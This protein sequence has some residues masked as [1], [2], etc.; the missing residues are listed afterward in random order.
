MNPLETFKEFLRDEPFWREHEKAVAIIDEMDRRGKQ[1]PVIFI[2][3]KRKGYRAVRC[4]V[5]ILK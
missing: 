4:R 3:A 1:R 2:P 5:E